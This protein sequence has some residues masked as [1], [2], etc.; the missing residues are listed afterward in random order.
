M[1]GEDRRLVRLA[2]G[3]ALMIN[4]IP[5]IS[6]ISMIMWLAINVGKLYK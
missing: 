4:T 5:K 2:L 3:P 6:F 1:V